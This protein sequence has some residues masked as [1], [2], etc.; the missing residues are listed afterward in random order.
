MCNEVYGCIHVDAGAYA[1]S[2]HLSHVLPSLSSFLTGSLS[3]QSRRAAIVSTDAYIHEKGVAATETPCTLPPIKIIAFADHSQP[4]MT[5]TASNGTQAVEALKLQ[6]E[7]SATYQ[8]WM[9]LF[10]RAL[11]GDITA[12]ELQRNIED[13]IL[14]EFQRISTQLRMLQKSLLET[15]A[16]VEHAKNGRL[17]PQSTAEVATGFA[18]SKQQASSA[19][20]SSSEAKATALAMWIARL[21]DLESEH[22]TV[23]VSLANRLVEHCTPNVRV[24]SESDSA[25]VTTTGTQ[26]RSSESADIRSLFKPDSSDDDEQYE[27]VPP[28][29]SAAAAAAA[30][31]AAPAAPTLRVH[32]VESCTLARLIPQRYHTHLYFVACRGAADDLDGSLDHSASE[33]DDVDDT[34]KTKAYAVAELVALPAK[35]ARRDGAPTIAHYAPRAVACRCANW[36]SAVAAIIRRQELLRAAI[37][38]LCEE[39]QGEISDDG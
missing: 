3:R 1:I 26:K 35:G 18:D 39:L 17:L 27:L 30:P 24:V 2:A 4:I 7:R 32:D 22:Y 9:S 12:T 6:R 21:Q 29:P 37:E 5:V 16:E 14:P 11:L 28:D 34:E 23:T 19:P 38:D 8:Q 20:P 33:S 13:I 31:E 36:S 25:A 10:H 15:A